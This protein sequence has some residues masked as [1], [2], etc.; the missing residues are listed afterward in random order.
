MKG[1][2]FFLVTASLMIVALCIICGC[3]Q[4]P[5]RT[6]ETDFTYTISGQITSDAV[7][8]TF[9]VD[10]VLLNA[11]DTSILAISQWGSGESVNYTAVYKTRINPLK[12]YVLGGRRIK[13]PPGASYYSSGDL[14]GFYRNYPTDY[15]SIEVN[16][17]SPN[18]TGINFRLNYVIP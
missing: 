11:E 14:V 4:D 18:R 15:T 10:V 6:K 16:A 3:G 2:R 12:V 9:E 13:S 17:Q 5:T 7:Y 8:A 1:L